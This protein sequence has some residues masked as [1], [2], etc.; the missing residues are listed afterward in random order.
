MFFLEL[1]N[2][3]VLDIL[4]RFRYLYRD[5]YDITKTNKPLS[6]LFGRGE[7]FVSKE[8]LQEVLDMGHNHDGS[9]RAAFSY[10]IKPDHYQGDDLEYKK[11][12]DNINDQLKVELGLES[13]ALSQLYP[14]KG[15]IDWHNNA[16]AAA[17]N[18]IFTWSETGDGWFKWLDGETINTMSDKKGWSCKVGYFANYEESKPVIYHCAYTDCWRMTLSFTLGHDKNYWEDMIDYIQCED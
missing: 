13:S 4:E 14:P 11:D 7:E 17:Y 6:D 5:K 16:N 18:V 15:F 8:Y 3:R 12:F 10:P 2:P 9:P 1:K